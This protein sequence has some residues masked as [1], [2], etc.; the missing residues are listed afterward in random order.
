MT[1]EQHLQRYAEQN[2]ELVG[3]LL[4]SLY[5]DDLTA[6]DSRDERAFENSSN[7]KGLWQKA[8]FNLQKWTSNS[9]ELRRLI[10]NCEHTSNIINEVYQSGTKPNVLEE[11]NMY[12]KTTIGVEDPE[13][14]GE[15]KVLEVYWN[16]LE[17]FLAFTLQPLSQVVNELSPTK[18]SILKIVAKIFDPLGVISPVTLQM[19]VMFQELCKLKVDWD[20]TLPQELRTKWSRWCEELGKADCIKIP[21]C[22]LHWVDEWPVRHQ[23]HGFRNSS[24]MGH[25]AV[26]YLRVETQA[27][28]QTSFVASK[29]RV[30][31]LSQFT[32]SR[33]ELMSAL[34]LSRLMNSVKGALES[35]VS[36]DETRC[37]TDSKTT[38][39][40][41]TGTDKEWKMF[42]E[43]RVRVQ[44]IRALVP[45][46][47]WFHCP[48]TENPADI[49]SRGMDATELS[50]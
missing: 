10:K 47:S 31:P 17:D 42:M 35:V 3:A 28:V 22:Y 7:Q 33:L 19:K 27:E 5:V 36:I 29:T 13:E 39:H 32:I 1:I 48:G 11:D 30:A 41:I 2:P 24:Q 46:G 8:R 40:W 38:L 25:I 20:D 16:F 9:P 21:R 26:V 44:E 37:W 50:Q 4:R 6:G 43:N 23:L 34:I 45:P 49:P 12:T 15:Q 18:R 14:H